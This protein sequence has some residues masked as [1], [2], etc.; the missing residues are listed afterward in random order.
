[1]N[2]GDRMPNAPIR[3]RSYLIV[4]G[5]RI[6]VGKENAHLHAP[7]TWRTQYDMRGSERAVLQGSFTGPRNEMSRTNFLTEHVCPLIN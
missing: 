1:M 3:V 2:S 7:A 4:F 6:R 5:K